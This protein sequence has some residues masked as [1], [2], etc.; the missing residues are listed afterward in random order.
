MDFDGE[1]WIGASIDTL[2]SHLFELAVDRLNGVA[3]V[4]EIK[5]VPPVKRLHVRPDLCDK[6]DT[7]RRT[8][9]E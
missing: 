9:S 1:A 2:Y 8:L 7:G 3:I 5:I 4:T 6:T